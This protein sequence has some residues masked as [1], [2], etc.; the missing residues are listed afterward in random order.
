[1]KI[2]ST[3]GKRRINIFAISDKL[4]LKHCFEPEIFDE[5]GEYYNSTRNRFEI[6]A[7]ESERVQSILEANSYDPT[8]VNDTHDYCIV[9]EKNPVDLI[10]RIVNE[11]VATHCEPIPVENRQ[12]F[13]S[14]K[15]CYWEGSTSSAATVF[16]RDVG[17]H[18]VLVMKDTDAVEQAVANGGM[19]IS[20]S[21]IDSSQLGFL[22]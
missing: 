14:W 9:K 10:Q 13:R 11:L 4:L 8:I 15:E 19:R 21:K 18:V 17:E 3:V 2:S 5:L 16:K 20:D 22:E 12:E 1:M 6:P 7:S